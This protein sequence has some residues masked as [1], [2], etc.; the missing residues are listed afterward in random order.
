MKRLCPRP[1]VDYGGAWSPRPMSAEDKDFMAFYFKKTVVRWRGRRRDIGQRTARLR[2]G[3][4]HRPLPFASEHF[5]HKTRL[6]FRAAEARDE[7]RRARSEGDIALRAV[8]RGLKIC[9][10]E[11]NIVSGSCMPP[12]SKLAEQLIHPASPAAQ[13]IFQLRVRN[14]LAARPAIRKRPEIDRFF[15]HFTKKRLHFAVGPVLCGVEQEFE[16][17][18]VKVRKTRKLEQFRQVVQF[19]KEEFQVAQR[20][21]IS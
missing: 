16:R 18:L 15:I 17:A 1:V 21:C 7:P 6:Q 9:W 5:L 3:Q 2:L 13:D 19:K 8:V 10:I 11:A 14:D 4:G 12:S 20:L